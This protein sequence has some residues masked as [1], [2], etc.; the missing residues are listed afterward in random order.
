MVGLPTSSCDPF[1][2]W[3]RILCAYWLLISE[4]FTA[5]AIE[6]SVA[7]VDS[8]MLGES[9]NVSKPSKILPSYLG[10][11]GV[12]GTPKNKLQ[13]KRCLETWG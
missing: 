7:F 6:V 3:S 1:L 5:T 12:F 11:G 2:K 8:Q 4:P 9:T 10:F 13:T